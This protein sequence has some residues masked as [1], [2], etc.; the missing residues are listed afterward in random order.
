LALG[1][2]E[3]A[4]AIDP[5]YLPAIC[6][7]ADLH[8]SM[9]MRRYDLPRRAGARAVQ[10]AEGVLIGFPEAAGT[11]GVL[12]F[13]REVIGGRPEGADLLER[14]VPLS[15]KVWLLPFYRGWARA[16][17]G[18]FTDAIADFEEA[19]RLSPM[20][21]GLA[22]PF[23]YV[24]LCAGEADRALRF[25]RDAV[26]ALPLTTTVHGVLAIVASVVGRHDEAVAH[27]ERA[28]HLGEG[29]P[30]FGPVLAYAL[31]RAG[32]FEAATAALET[33]LSRGGLGPPP[34]LLAPAELVLTTPERALATLARAE[35]EGCPYRHLAR[36]DLRLNGVRTASQAAG[37]HVKER[38]LIGGN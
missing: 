7:I 24:L 23:G 21:P 36:F 38:H 14:A 32:R 12:G 4:A 31:A 37:G 13:A 20:D 33:L 27:A 6:G 8:I 3:Q 9:A 35:E 11:L 15:P 17:R 1:R 26:A 25:L 18:A 5:N 22:G 34:S 30:I 10:A 29:S 16:G 2:L 19:L 28:M